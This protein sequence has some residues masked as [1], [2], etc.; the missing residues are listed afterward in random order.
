ML[1]WAPSSCLWWCIFIIT[2]RGVIFQTIVRKPLC[3]FLFFFF[4]F[5]SLMIFP[6]PSLYQRA[7][8][9]SWGRKQQLSMNELFAVDP[10]GRSAHGC[11][12]LAAGS[13]WVMSHAALADIT[14]PAR[15]NPVARQP[16]AVQ[17]LAQPR[18]TQ[19]LIAHQKSYTL[20]MPADLT[21][22]WRWK[23]ASHL[24]SVSTKFANQQRQ[25]VLI[26][27]KAT[28]LNFSSSSFWSLECHKPFPWCSSCAQRWFDLP[29]RS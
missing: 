28:L 5:C 6:V 26:A 29:V 17:S 23:I 19:L 2:L 10:S 3:S 11:N 27:S 9:V 18:E 21:W 4:F 8:F 7:F 20:K 14:Q 25:I 24:N 12:N 16:F 1:R 15:S 13:C 22:G